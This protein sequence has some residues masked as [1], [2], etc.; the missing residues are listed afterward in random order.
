MTELRALALGG[1]LG[2]TER[3]ARELTA[4]F[5]Q[6]GRAWKALG[7]ALHLQH[8]DGIAALQRAVRLLAEDAEAHANLAIALLAQN[9]C[10][11]AITSLQ[12]ALQLKPDD[13]ECHNNLG[14]A[15]RA[16][17]RL[18]EALASYRRAA[19]LRPD[20]ADLHNNLGNAYQGLHRPSEAVA[21]Y[22][23]ALALRPDYCEAQAALGS[24][25]LDL[26]RAAE[27]VISL[28]RAVDLDPKLV[29]AHGNLGIALLM[30]GRPAEA[31]ASCQRALE[32]NPELAEA[33]STLGTAL[34]DLGRENEAV[35]AYERALALRP[36]FADALSNLAIAL[37][38]QGR[39]DDA[40]SHARHA[41]DLKPDSAST[42][43]VLADAHADRGEFPQ[44]EQWLQK[45]IAIDPHSPQ[46]W[47][48]LAYLR[49]MDERDA[50]WREQALRIVS[51]GN[52]S[53]RAEVQL[54][55]ALGKYF[56][57]LRQYDDAFGQFRMANEL[58]RRYRVPYDRTRAQR[59]TDRLLHTCDRRWLEHARL[60]GAKSN[61][62]VL[63]IGMPRSGTSLIEQ[64]LAS[65]TEVF[66]AGELG[67]WNV[68]GASYDFV[69]PSAAAGVDALHGLGERYLTLLR[70]LD[71]KAL[72]VVDKMPDNFRHL[73]LIHA[74]LPEARFIH[75]QRNPLDTCLSIYFQ[76]FKA[77]H[78][79][80]T[81]LGDLAHYYQEYWRLMQ[82]WR[83][84]LPAQALLEIPYEALVADPEPWSRRLIEHL[85][86]AWDRRCLDFSQ[87][88]RSVTTASKWQVRQKISTTSVGRWR[89]YQP[90]LGELTALFALVDAIEARSP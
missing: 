8:K 43:V 10:A 34:L 71:G 19:E 85:G 12:R 46:A 88:R 56:D 24:A 25:L 2:E 5:P 57:D 30:L 74:A 58:S 62:P 3:L 89:H 22:Q 52:L 27:A 87:T 7:V 44:A 26:G 64:I 70:S 54:R 83:S 40:V 11:E 29:R 14:N 33:Y 76:D 53:L 18:E 78:L 9:R 73:G 50:R 16:G 86:L 23:R 4:L 6:S 20:H 42:M 82:H 37:R 75:V 90:Y 80:A 65:H 81:D 49:T 17:G 67:Y 84:L 39:T 45:A 41:L 47:A 61:L 51:G 55:Y 48:G 59:E 60:H 68:A 35:G 66:G 21:C 72:R 31:L 77:A 15:L 28:R 38:L 1:R 63:I 69:R 13:A 79:Y 32:L 36:G